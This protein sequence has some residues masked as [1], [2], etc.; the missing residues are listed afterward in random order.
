MGE[1]KLLTHAA[2]ARKPP[3]AALRQ[4]TRIPPH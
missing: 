3:Y 2:S 4:Y 1:P